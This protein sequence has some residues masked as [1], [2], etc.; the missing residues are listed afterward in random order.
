MCEIA[1]GR[2][3]KRHGGSMQN[4]TIHITF[5]WSVLKMTFEPK[6]YTASLCVTF[7][8]VQVGLQLGLNGSNSHKQAQKHC[9]KQE[10]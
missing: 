7:V 3:K 9:R 6:T 1:L 10:K 5:K 4:L 8:G 2:L